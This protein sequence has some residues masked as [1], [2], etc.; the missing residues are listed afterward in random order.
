MYNVV[1]ARFHVHAHTLLEAAAWLEGSSRAR[2][3]YP[4]EDERV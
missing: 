4:S 1:V 3:Q 2:D